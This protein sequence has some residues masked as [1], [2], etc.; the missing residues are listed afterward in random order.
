VNN[1]NTTA[2]SISS[3]GVFTLPLNS[4]GTQPTTS[5][6]VT[7][8][9]VP[10]P[11]TAAIPLF[12][13]AVA[14]TTG[15]VRFNAGGA[16]DSYNSDP[17]PG[18]GN[19]VAYAP[20]IAGYSAV[21]ASQNIATFAA[22]VRLGNAVVHGYA[23]GYNTLFPATTNWLSY[24]GGGQLVGPNTLPATSID[25]NR[26][27]TTPVPYQPEF[28]LNPPAWTTLPTACS[29]DSGA[30]INNSGILGIPTATAPTVY[31]ASNGINLPSGKTVVIQGPV[32]IESAT[33]V[34]IA[35]G[36]V[37]TT[38][39][40]SLQIFLM[41]SGTTLNLGGNGITNTN[42]VPLP[43]KVAIMTTNASGTVSTVST[44]QP[45][46]GVIYLPNMPIIVS[47]AQPIYG[48]IVGQ[49]VTFTNAVAI[50]YDLALRNPMP[51]YS[52]VSLLTEMQYG[53]AFDN[54]FAPSAFTNM[55]A[56]VP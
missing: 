32:V 19:Y 15:N 51:A 54:L 29:T 18:S 37:L 6:T 26:L 43:K 8:N 23:T 49:G 46:Y 39:Q 7:Y 48:S 28:L 21:I 35:G 50:H 16:V 22:S 9:A 12:V 13:N 10:A 56:T 36:I 24:G 55:V 53:A 5:S 31:Y 40:A 17:V 11:E 27:V 47:T 3:Q 1:Y 20:A 25:S 4:G 34:L 45:F 42:A 41:S 38:P 52:G 30:T 14:A 33:N 2:P 44:T